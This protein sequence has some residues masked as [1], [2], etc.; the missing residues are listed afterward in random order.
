MKVKIAIIVLIVFL[1]VFY[2]LT[3]VNFLDYENPKKYEEI[4]GITFNDF[5]GLEF[6][7]NSLY[8]NEHFA[9]IKNFY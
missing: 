8:G 6:F 5:R 1:I 9:Y 3:K 7:Q 2:S 4:N